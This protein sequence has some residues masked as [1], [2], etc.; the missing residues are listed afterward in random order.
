VVSGHGPVTGP[1]VFDATEAYLR[2]VR[3]V[4][5]DARRSGLSPLAAAR[6]ADL[7]QFAA[8]VDSERLV[9]NLHRVY[10]ELDGMPAGAPLDVL[11]SFREMAEYHGGLPACHA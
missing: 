8:L 6:G 3:G 1:E 5:Q 7:G 9:G 10:A 2:W 11:A 4:A